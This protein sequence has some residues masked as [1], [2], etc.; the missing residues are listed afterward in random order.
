[1]CV[2]TII[3]GLICVQWSWLW[4]NVCPSCRMSSWKFRKRS[5]APVYSRTEELLWYYVVHWCKW[6]CLV[7]YNIDSCCY[8]AVYYVMQYRVAV[9]LQYRGVDCVC[10]FT[11][12]YASPQV[13]L[14]I[15]E[16]DMWTGELVTVCLCL[17]CP[18]PA[19]TSLYLC[20]PLPCTCLHY[21]HVP[22]STTDLYQITSLLYC[23][24]TLPLNFLSFIKGGQDM[25]HVDTPVNIFIL[26]MRNLPFFILHALLIILIYMVIKSDWL[27]AANYLC[28]LITGEE[29]KV[30]TGNQVIK[31]P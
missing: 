2:N 16:N 10:T 9:Q 4:L 1:M 30:H 5:I 3:L 19:S 24:R 21:S 8:S 14:D 25:I 22:V 13:G 12:Q 15:W 29:D 28:F 31:C 18:V 11:V 23:L 27:H 20:P 26:M 7:K 17:H 6:W